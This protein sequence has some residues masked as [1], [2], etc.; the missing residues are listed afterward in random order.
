MDTG[1]ALQPVDSSS[2]SSESSVDSATVD[3]LAAN[4]EFK[5]LSIIIISNLH[6]D[7]SPE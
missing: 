5:K 2:E 4:R 1:G 7:C 3:M 6:R